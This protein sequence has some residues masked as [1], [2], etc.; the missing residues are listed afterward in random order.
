M[1]RPIVSTTLFLLATSLCS[2]QDLA[3]QEVKPEK[4][5][6]RLIRPER[7]LEGN[8]ENGSDALRA[9]VRVLAARG[10]GDDAK[11]LTAI[12]G[13][14]DERRAQ[15]FNVDDQATRIG[16]LERVRDTYVD[17]G[18]ESNAASLDYVIALGRA[19]R[20]GEDTSKISRPSSLDLAPGESLSSELE[21]IVGQAVAVFGQNGREEAAQEAVALTRFY[22]ERRARQARAMDLRY[23]EGRAPVLVLASQAHRRLA[24][25]GGADMREWMHW[26]AVQARQRVEDPNALLGP[27]PVSSMT[28]ERIIDG[29]GVAADYWESTGAEENSV[30][31][32]NLAA[33][34]V[35]RRENKAEDL[36]SSDAV[37]RALQWSERA[38]QARIK[39]ER[40]VRE[41]RAETEALRAKIA[42]MEA[43]LDR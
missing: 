28:L 37:P 8:P 2:G 5:R 20:A 36:S 19:A 1:A 23:I 6:I 22:R 27:S 43:L 25:V 18:W 15:P 11:R 16:M 7:S 4:G 39:L 33:Y 30:R 35:A 29:L 13:E 41:L 31:C 34:Y 3:E 12:I 10:Y 32:R 38:A 40:R 14:L 42:E 9:A 17:L 21:R 24:E 26:M